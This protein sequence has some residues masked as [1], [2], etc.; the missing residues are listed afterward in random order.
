M[1]HVFK[2]SL[3]FFAVT[4]VVACSSTESSSSE[5]VGF[6]GLY[7]SEGVNNSEESETTVLESSTVVNIE[8]TSTITEVV[9]TSSTADVPTTTTTAAPTTTTTV[10]TTSTT[11]TPTTTTSVAPTTTTAA[12]TTTTTVAPTTTTVAPTTTKVTAA[13]TTTTTVPPTTTT[14]APTT[15]PPTTTK[16]PVS[17]VIVGL[18]DTNQNTSGLIKGNISNK[19][20]KIYHCP[21]QRDYDK[22]KIDPSKG[23]RYFNTE[24]EAVAAGWRKAKR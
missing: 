15:I 4:L 8:T 3:L 1:K 24:E 11:A 7:N 13:P 20:E 2:I 6:R 12:P 22:T 21:G 18:V 5:T 16:A 9:T 17:T 19:G 10:A 23:E 14:V